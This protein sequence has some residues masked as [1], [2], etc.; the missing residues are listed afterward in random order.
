MYA[1]KSAGSAQPLVWAHAEYV[2]LLRSVVDGKVFDRIP[3]VEERYAVAREKRTFTSTIEIFQASRGQS[4]PS[5]PASRCASSTRDTFRCASPQTTGPTNET[6]DS[7]AVGLAG[8]FV[9]IATRPDLAGSILFTLCWVDEGQP[10]RWLGRNLEV[11][12]SPV[13]QEQKTAGVH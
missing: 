13:P 8:S 4:T 1:G 9:D 2:K 11:A 12:V 10:P 6:L 7:D 5:S 3:V